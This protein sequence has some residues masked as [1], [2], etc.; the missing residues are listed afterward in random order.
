[1]GEVHGSEFTAL[2]DDLSEAHETTSTFFHEIQRRAESVPSTRPEASV[3]E[4]ADICMYDDYLGIVR[5]RALAH[6]ELVVAA[7]PLFAAVAA[8]LTHA[9][10][11]P[12]DILQ[13]VALMQRLVTR[14]IRSDWATGREPLVSSAA[15]LAPAGE[16]DDYLVAGRQKCAALSLL[17]RWKYGHQ[18]FALANRNASALLREAREALAAG[19][20]VRASALVNVAA[21][22]V[23]AI[24]STMNYAAAMSSEQYQSAVRPTMSPPC[25]PTELTGSMNLD[26]RSYRDALEQF[27]ADCK[28]TF[29]DTQTQF[30]DLA[31]ARE[32]LL[33]ADLQDITCHVDLTYRLVGAVSALDEREDGSA[34]QAL[35][36]RLLDRTQRYSE[37]LRLGS[38]TLRL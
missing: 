11:W 9:R 16:S 27:L 7:T 10:M 32:R 26:H 20:Y 3:D 34:V 22:E 19:D 17:E 38:R 14:G 36:S 33:Q 4:M 28:A 31:H 18:L 37:L 30:G 13:I 2:R 25:T 5:T 6:T 23:A 12:D 1:M 29:A 8:D 21:E 15:S 35:R 24:T